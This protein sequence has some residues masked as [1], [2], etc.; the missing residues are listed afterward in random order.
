MTKISHENRYKIPQQNINK[1]N[2]RILKQNYAP[3]H[4][5]VEFIPDSKS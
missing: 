4:D 1:M 5:Q 3:C 2:P